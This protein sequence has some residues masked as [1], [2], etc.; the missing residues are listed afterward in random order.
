M[1]RQQPWRLAVSATVQRVQYAVL[2]VA[3]LLLAAAAAVV[4]V[5]KKASSWATTADLRIE[6]V[7]AVSCGAWIVDE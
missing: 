2:A 5:A 6:R 3:V 7:A 1:K 4:V